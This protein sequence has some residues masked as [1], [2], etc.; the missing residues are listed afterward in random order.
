MTIVAGGPQK[1]Q[2]VVLSG[3]KPLSPDS[4]SLSPACLGERVAYRAQKLEM[5]T[6][7]EAINVALQWLAGEDRL[8]LLEFGVTEAEIVER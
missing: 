5:R 2:G 6:K 1:R 8:D 7:R 4:P 3:P